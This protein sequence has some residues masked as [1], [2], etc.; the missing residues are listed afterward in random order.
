[1]IFILEGVSF[2]FELRGLV[3]FPAE[4]LIVEVWRRRRRWHAQAVLVVDGGIGKGRLMADAPR[5]EKGIKKMKM[6]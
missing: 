3:S 6:N 4:P 5:L 2:S 1:M